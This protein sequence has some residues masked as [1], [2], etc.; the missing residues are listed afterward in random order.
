MKWYIIV[1]YLRWFHF[2]GRGRKDARI[3]DG[4]VLK[5]GMFTNKA[6]QAQSTGKNEGE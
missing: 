1:F 3:S 6:F 2:E 5:S 4:R